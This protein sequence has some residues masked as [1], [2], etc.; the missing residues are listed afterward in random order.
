MAE[1]GLRFKLGV[2]I[3]GTLAILAGLVVFFGRSPDLFSNKAS[4]DLLFPEAPGIAPGHA[5]PQIRSPNRSG[6]VRR[7]RSR[8]RPGPREGPRRSPLSAAE[9]RGTDD[10]KRDLERRRGHRLPP[11]T[12]RSR[13]ARPARRVL[14]AGFADSRRPAH[15]AAQLAHPGF[16]RARQR[17]SNPWIDSSAPSRSSKSSNA[18]APRWKSPSTS[19]PASPRTHGVSFPI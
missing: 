2:F 16:R 5:H 6:R 12:R 17:R 8:E 9:E 7:T 10:H 4:Y 14:A 15:H 1:R 13:T 3:A 11:Q 19:S 18:S